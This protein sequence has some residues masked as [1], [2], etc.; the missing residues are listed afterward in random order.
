MSIIIQQDATIYSLFISAN[1]STCFGWYLHPSSGAH[2]T[3]STVSGITETVTATCRGRNWMGTGSRPVTFTTGSSNGLNNSRYCNAVIWAPDDGWRYHPKHVEQFADINKLYIVASC[4]IIIDTY[5]AM[6]GQ[7][8]IRMNIKNRP[9]SHLSEP[10]LTAKSSFQ[11][12]LPL[13]LQQSHSN[14]TFSV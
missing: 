3:V 8:N 4:W 11:D 13:Y 9:K 14:V 7:L 12:T 10:F 5:Y 1:C 6:H 2:I